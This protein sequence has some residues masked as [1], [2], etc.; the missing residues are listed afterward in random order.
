[1]VG[2]SYFHERP[3]LELKSYQLGSSKGL[4]YMVS[5]RVQNF[6]H[7]QSMCVCAQLLSCV[8]LFA[9]LWTVACQAP[10]STGFSRQEYWSGLPF[11]SPLH[12]YYTYFT[13]PLRLDI[14]DVS[15]LSFCFGLKVFWD[16]KLLTL[17]I[18]NK[19]VTNLG[20]GCQAHT[21]V[22]ADLGLFL[23]GFTKVKGGFDYFR[24]WGGED[25]CYLVHRLGA[26]WPREWDR[27]MAWPQ[28]CS[29]CPSHLSRDCHSLGPRWKKKS[30]DA[31]R[32][33]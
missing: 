23:V 12:G 29:A 24:P 22:C 30:P 10:L 17:T 3:A 9:T 6:T 26:G 7:T 5:S 28:T 19:V 4:A 25:L 16:S 14:H 1:M 21:T 8:W 27:G 13:I 31:L 2:L 33:R 20:T 11:P 15:R 18:L 32:T